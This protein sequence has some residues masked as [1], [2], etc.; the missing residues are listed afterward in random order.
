MTNSTEL[1]NAGGSRNKVHMQ[2]PGAAE[3]AAAEKSEK[4]TAFF[5]RGLLRTINQAAHSCANNQ[6]ANFKGKLITTVM[7]MVD[8]GKSRDH[9]QEFLA[10]VTSQGKI[11]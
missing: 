2:Q 10:R 11:E 8:D 6:F 5:D 3:W 1:K 9:V 7:K 4:M